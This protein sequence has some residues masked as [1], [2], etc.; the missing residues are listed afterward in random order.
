[1]RQILSHV[2]LGMLLLLSCGLVAQETTGVISGSVTDSSG[3]VVPNATVTL[4]N[5]DRNAVIRS[6]KT[7]QNG[8]F[9]APLLPIGNYVVKVEASNFKTYEKTGV[10]LNVNDRLQVNAQLQLGGHQEQVNVQADVLQ[11]QTQDATATGLINGTQ[12]RELSL[13]SRNYEELVRLMPGVTTDLAS[14]TLY[15]GVSA[16]SGGTNQVDFSINGSLSGQNNWTVDGADNVDRGGNYTLLNYPSV[17]AI[18]EFK[19]LRGNYNA[20][21]GRGAGGQINVIT[22]SGGSQFHGGLYEFFRNDVLDANTYLNNQSGTPRTPFRY[23]DFGGT[24]G[25]PVYIPGIYNTEKNK[26]FFFFSEEI[27]RVKESYSQLAVVP[28]AAE[29][30]GD[31]SADCFAFDA[32]GNCTAYGPSTT[33]ITPAAAAY[34]KDIY[35]HIAVPPPGTNNIVTNV[36]NTF[37]YRQEIVRIDH[38]FS[39]KLSVFGHYINDNIPTVEDGGL[40]NGNPLPGIATTNTNSPGRSIVVTATS[41]FTPT[42]LNELSYA[43]SYG[44]VISR[45]SGYLRYENSPDLAAIYQAAGILPFPTT[46]D[47]VPNISFAIEQG[48]SGFGNYNDYNHNHSGWDNLTKV[49]GEHTLK[50]GAQYNWYQ[51]H[52]NAAGG[53]TG[54]FNFSGASLGAEF[55]NFLTGTPD[56]YN[57]SSSDVDAVIRQNVIEAY[58]QDEWR[59]RPNLTV[60]YGVRFSRFGSP[61]DS[62]NKATNFVPALYDPSKAPTLGYDGNLCLPSACAGTPPPGS[63]LPAITP[64][65]NYDPYNGMVGPG[66]PGHSSPYGNQVSSTPFYFSPRIGFAWDPFKTGRTSIRGGYGM[67]VDSVAVNIVENNIFGNPPFAATYNFYS[68]TLDNPSNGGAAVNNSAPS[69][70]G[71][72]K[73]WH[74]PYTQQ[75]NIDLQHQLPGGA[76]I[77]IGYYGSKGTHLFNYVDINQPSPGAFLNSPAYVAAAVATDNAAHP[78]TNDVQVPQ[79]NSGTANLLNLVRPYLGYNTINEYL[80]IFS[81]NYHSLQTSLQKQFKGN[82]LI[83]INYTWSKTLSNLHLPSEYSVPQVTSYLQQDYGPTRFSRDHVFNANFVYSLP[84]LLQQQGMV[85]HVL[86]GWEISGIVQVESGGWINPGTAS[87]NDPAGVGIQFGN[88]P[89]SG[90]AALPVQVGDP[91]QGAP[92]N[93]T[94]WF[95]TAAFQ[96]VPSCDPTVAAPKCVYTYG[97]SR[98]SSILG[99]GIQ[100][101]DLSLFKNIK[102]TERV[103]MQFRAEA[104]NVFNHTNPGTIDTTLGDPNYGM[105]TG[106]HDPRIMQLGLK[107]NF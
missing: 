37:N 36:N 68:A 85:G 10:V 90:S 78:G 27:R 4:L 42:L 53:N 87:T 44:G 18:A 56:Y 16:P 23:N 62:N 35:S 64:N 95:N 47:R 77:D 21:F 86:G 11:V 94:Q 29:R 43:Y 60:S 31:F 67:F 80:P 61:Y 79:P 66:I 48:F 84:W 40:F 93:L 26:T 30:S 34:L 97:N 1:M 81:S 107:L 58:A 9:S 38:Q 59:V 51:K 75:W 41:T 105:V 24:I 25:G 82:S 103:G 65:P 102:F 76:I 55:Y 17:D 96:D 98:L 73:N 39:S 52:E 50:F 89:S 101:W 7:D 57:Q 13:R 33:A 15:V 2:L 70:G 14:D 49:W 69:L 72:A 3:A 28:N 12:V 63:G 92:H 19:V 71:L 32:N 99:P 83:G 6:V 106:F 8:T 100:T 88:T 20:E 45:N 104:F 91:N 22:R 74:Q 54:T 5:A 46:L